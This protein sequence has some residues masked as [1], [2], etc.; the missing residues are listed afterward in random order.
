MDLWMKATQHLFKYVL[1]TFNNK[2]FHIF[3][4]MIQGTKSGSDCCSLVLI[5]ME[6]RRS[7]IFGF[8][9]KFWIRYKDDM[10]MITNCIQLRS[11]EQVQSKILGLLYPEF[12]FDIETNDKMA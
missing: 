6:L 4:S 10:F 11:E 9:I 7:N 8:L 5:V 1:F 3:G 12:S 2:L